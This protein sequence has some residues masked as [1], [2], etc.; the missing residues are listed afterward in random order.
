MTLSMLYFSVLINPLD[1]CRISSEFNNMYLLEHSPKKA[2]KEP[3]ESF[4]NL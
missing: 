4:P 3:A 2:K 1:N